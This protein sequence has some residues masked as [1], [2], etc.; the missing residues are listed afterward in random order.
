MCGAINCT[1]II[2]VIGPTM[3]EEIFQEKTLLLPLC[4]IMICDDM[5][6]ILNVDASY[7]GATHDSFM[8]QNGELRNFRKHF[9]NL[10]S[11]HESAALLVMT[12]GSETWAL[13]MGLMRKL[14][15]TQRAMERTMLGV[16]LRDRIR[17]DDIRSRTKD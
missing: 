4:T 12:Y 17:N 9:E 2:A 15:V 5:N 14:K 7:S 8:W 10:C 16:S 1:Q 6:S 13:T 11:T 3:Y